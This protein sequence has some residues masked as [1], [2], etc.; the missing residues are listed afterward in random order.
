MVGK[1]TVYSGKQ[2]AADKLTVGFKSGVMVGG[3]KT[4][5]EQDTPQN[6]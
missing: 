6:W 1:V 3:N 2:I 5:S 4:D